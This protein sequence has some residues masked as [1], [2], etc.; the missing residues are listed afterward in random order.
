MNIENYYTNFYELDEALGGY[1]DKIDWEKFTGENYSKMDKK[2][3]T[4]Y[5]N[6]IKIGS[7]LNTPR[8]QKT[9]W[10]RFIGFIDGKK[11][12]KLYNREFYEYFK[13]SFIWENITEIGFDLTEEDIEFL[14]KIP[15]DVYVKNKT[16]TD[17]GLNLNKQYLM[18]NLFSIP[19]KYDYL[20]FFIY[21]YNLKETKEDYE[22][23]Q[24]KE[25]N[26]IHR[27]SVEDYL[28]FNYFIPQ[29]EKE[30]FSYGVEKSIILENPTKFSLKI[31]PLR[32]R[33]DL[34]LGKKISFL[35]IFN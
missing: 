28:T 21:A 13:D 23:V 26:Y 7:I 5:H 24:K 33:F 12:N 8:F 11:I 34:F 20:K 18:N 19:K 22:F 29:K 30:H 25:L 31:I 3:I 15:L 9:E 27:L 6:S 1:V 16:F 35:Q 14:E 17:I 4:K 2:F 10:K 32:I